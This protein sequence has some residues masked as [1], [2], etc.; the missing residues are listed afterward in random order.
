MRDKREG[1]M[2]NVLFMIV[3]CIAVIAAQTGC[4]KSLAQEPPYPTPTP[5]VI[6]DYEDNNTINSIVKAGGVNNTSGS[7][8]TNSTIDS[9]GLVPGAG[10][11]Y[12]SYAFGVTGTVVMLPKPSSL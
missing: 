6:D 1:K 2:K 12:G 4:G 3:V 7:V 5:L 10:G 9:W 8:G 11:K